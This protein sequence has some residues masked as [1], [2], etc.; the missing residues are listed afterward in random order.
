MS[1]NVGFRP[2]TQPTQF[3]GFEF[4][5]QVLENDTV[6]KVKSINHPQ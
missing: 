1:V 2:S 5:R 3:H 6:I 4:N